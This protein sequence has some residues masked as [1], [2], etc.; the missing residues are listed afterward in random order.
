MISAQ[1]EQFTVVEEKKKGRKF[2]SFRKLRNLQ[3]I[4]QCRA[5]EETHDTQ[6]RKQRHAIKGI[7][8]SKRKQLL[9]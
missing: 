5:S 1:I 2:N 4:N 8:L 7:A 3:K 6:K 9:D